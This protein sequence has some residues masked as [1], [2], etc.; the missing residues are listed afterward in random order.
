MKKYTNAYII[1]E[2]IYRHVYV[3]TRL[4]GT[5]TGKRPE[6]FSTEAERWNWV[7]QVK[8]DDGTALRGRQNFS[9]ADVTTD[10]RAN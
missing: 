4:S 1:Y 8:N 3:Y 10:S 6:K 7:L 2:C 9:S 5:P